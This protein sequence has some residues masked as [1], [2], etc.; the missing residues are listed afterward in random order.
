MEKVSNIEHLQFSHFASN[1]ETCLLLLDVGYIT[2]L[3][4]EPINADSSLV[5]TEHFGISVILAKQKSEIMS[6]RKY[7]NG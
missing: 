3:K 1:L 6:V 2:G 4:S 5:N 7:W